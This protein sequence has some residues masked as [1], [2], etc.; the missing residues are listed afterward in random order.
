LPLVLVGVNHR[1][2]ELALREKISL[3]EN[4]IPL[5]LR[6]FLE[7][8][9]IAECFLL[10]TCNRTELYAICAGNDELPARF[11]GFFH[12]VKKHPPDSAL[13]QALYV[14]RE[15]EAVRHLFAVSCGLDSMVLGETQILGQVKEAYHSCQ[16]AGATGA[17]LHSL[18]QKALATGKKVHTLTALGQH[19]VSFGYAAAAVARLIFSSLQNH[20]LMVIGTGEMAKLTLQNLFAMGVQEVIVVSRHRERAATLAGRFQGKVLRLGRLA[21]ELAKAD[22]VI[23]ATQAP[24]Y[25]ITA[26]RLRQQRQRGKQEG[27]PLLLIDLAVPRN[28]DP[29]VA[30]LEGVYLY[31]LDDLQSIIN[32]NLKVRENEALKAQDI[33]ETQVREFLCWY[34]RQRAIPIIAGLRRK[35]EQIRQAKLAQFNTAALSAREQQLADKL[36]RSLVNTLLNEPIM[37][38]KD[39]CLQD[40]YATA[41]KYA[42]QIFGLEP[43]DTEDPKENR[44]NE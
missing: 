5:A 3:Q 42:R 10:S 29:A 30:S 12:D 43:Q 13:L 28:V 19:A 21:G 20:T 18:C 35:T 14:R 31:N 17:Y 32:E 22:V 40:D 15:E 36:T 6:Y 34:R 11:L 23:C 41:E 4:E 26:E 1:Q 8:K 33:V 25:V 27:K 37:A 24:H 44:S 2:A 39:L 7:D 9:G 16:A 38:L